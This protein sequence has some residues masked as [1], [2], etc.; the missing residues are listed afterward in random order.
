MS[1]RSIDL[2]DYR[3]AE[4]HE[5]LDSA[6]ILLDNNRYKDSI[7]RSYYA[8]FDAI[9]SVL[10]MENVDFKH[11]SQVIGYFNKNYIHTGKFDTKYIT[12]INSAFQIRNSCDYDD[13]YIA[14]RTDA[15]EQYC[16]AKEFVENVEKYI[17]QN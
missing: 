16:A 8:L 7:N 13:F 11:H 4:A 10:A 15:E 9:R 1:E 17:S 5:K 14:L 6:K 2:R 12:V 3:L